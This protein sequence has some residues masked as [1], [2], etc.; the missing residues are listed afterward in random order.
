MNFMLTKTEESLHKEDKVLAE[1]FHAYIEAINT[2]DYSQVSRLLHENAVFCVEGQIYSNAKEIEAFHANFWN[3]L[4]DSK[5]WAA[6]DPKII[7]HDCNCHICT[8]PYHYSGYI[9]GKYIEGRGITTDVYIYKE[10]TKQWELL[11]EHSSQ[12]ENIGV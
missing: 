8:Y 1:V 2:H 4:K 11:H 9:E 10:N 5:Y 6:E 7:Y 12:S 3:T